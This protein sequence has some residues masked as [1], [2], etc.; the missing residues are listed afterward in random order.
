MWLP[1]R[2]PGLGSAFERLFRA[3]PERWHG[4]HPKAAG[5]V[6]FG[7]DFAGAYLLRRSV[8]LPSEIGSL[9]GQ[10]LA[11]EGL[12]QLASNDLNAAPLTP[13]PRTSFGKIAALE[14][15]FYMRNQL[16]RDVDW[17]SMAHS[18]EVRVPLVDTT[19]LGTIAPLL[20]DG[21]INGKRLLASAPGTPVNETV[22]SRRK[23]G[24]SVPIGPWQQ[25]LLANRDMSAKRPPATPPQLWARQWLQYVA[26]QP[27]AA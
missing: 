19:L 18:I 15:Q 4:L 25:S 1:S 2:V 17:A 5:T 20:V 11:R 12:R 16:L 26:S 14:S 24:F 6:R 10:D 21:R 8:Y 22:V 23:T 27:I 9:I 13:S 3:V 7:G